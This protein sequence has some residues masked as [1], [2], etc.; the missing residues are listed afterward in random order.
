[1]LYVDLVDARPSINKVE[2][3]MRIY[4][5]LTSDTVA[6]YLDTSGEA[7]FKRGYRKL[8]LEAP[9]RE[10][11]AFG[12]IKLSGW[13][14]E[15]A[16]YDPM[17]GSGTLV[18]EAICYA[19]NIAPGLNR[20][21]AFEKFADIDA[22]LFMQMKEGAK[23]AINYQKKL[24][25]FASDINKTAIQIAQQN[26]QQI[27]LDQ[28]VTFSSGDFLSKMA[29]ATTGV[30]LTNPPYGIRLDELDRLAN[31]YPQLAS[32]LK[33]NYA[34]WECYFFSGDLRLPKLFRLKPKCKTV[35]FNGAIE[36]RLY[37]FSMVAGSNRK[38]KTSL[39]S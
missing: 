6:I 23:Q 32:H 8:K 24:Q 18:V 4:N 27:K 20:T 22:D 16:F 31:L 11:L 7:L 14:P 25:I 17:C 30:L 37:G 38:D 28:Y 19:L 33:Q 2:P 12:L 13:Q 29:P 10:N 34:G 5:F 26:F 9:I 39:T 15:Q 1:M 35:L 3:D 36:C 21:F